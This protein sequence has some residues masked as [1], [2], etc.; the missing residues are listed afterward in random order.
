[1]PNWCI[2]DYVA[3]GEKADIERLRKNLDDA[4]N[5]ECR[6]ENGFGNWWLGNILD[7]HGL[8]WQEYNCRGEVTQLSEIEYDFYEEGQSHFTFQTWT[9]WRPCYEAL[10]AIEAIYPEVELYWFAEEPG[11]ELLETN[12]LSGKYHPERVKLRVTE[13]DGDVWEEYYS[14]EEELLEIL[15][16][17]E[18]DSSENFNN[19]HEFLDEMDRTYGEE[20]PYEIDFVSIRKE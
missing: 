12:D 2:T 4:F 17:A 20:N 6:I 16:K 18:K 10:K 9:A 19:W 14:T 15:N 5:T 3:V 1:M 11:C 8:D 7:L 13:S